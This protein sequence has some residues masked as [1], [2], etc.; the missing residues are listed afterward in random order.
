VRVEDDLVRQA[1]ER[2]PGQAQP[3]LRVRNDRA[4][5]GV[6]RDEDDQPVDRELLARGPRQRDVPRLRRVEDAAENSCYW[7]SS[8]SPSS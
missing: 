7:N 4:M 5:A 8:T 2:E 6:R 1:L 3:G